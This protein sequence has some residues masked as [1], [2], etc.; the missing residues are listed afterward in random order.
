MEAEKNIVVYMELIPGPNKTDEICGKTMVTGTM[1]QGSTVRVISLQK[2]NKI[3]LFGPTLLRNFPLKK[4]DFLGIFKNALTG[5]Y[6][7]VL[8]TVQFLGCRCYVLGVDCTT[9]LR[10]LVIIVLSVDNTSGLLNL[11][12]MC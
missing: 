10:W 12:I 6:C 11:K 8:N 1:H 5:F 7:I 2:I 9:N 4:S 3:E